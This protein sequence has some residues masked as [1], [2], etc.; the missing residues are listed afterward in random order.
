MDMKDENEYLGALN[1]LYEKSLMLHDPG[2]FNK[3]LYFFFVD[4]LAHIDYTASI[5]AFHYESPKIIMGGEYLRWRIDEEK[6]GDRVKFK[7]FINWLR[8]EHPGKFAALPSLW[9]MIY[10]TEN[11]ASYRSF[12]IVTDPNSKTPLPADFFYAV[13]DEFFDTDFLKSLYNENSLATLF[14][15]YSTQC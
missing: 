9:Q 15:T 1:H 13:T 8:E 12:R 2:S 7:G 3:T 10:D 6:K 5:Y 14:V 11:P 4:A